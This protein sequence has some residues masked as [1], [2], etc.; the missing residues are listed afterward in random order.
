[1][2]KSLAQGRGSKPE[3]QESLKSKPEIQGRGMQCDF[4]N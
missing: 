4:E 3:I 1:M 2:T